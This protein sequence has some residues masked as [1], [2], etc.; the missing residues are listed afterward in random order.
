MANLA[1]RHVDSELADATRS[2]YQQVG[3]FDYGI[4]KMTKVS[5]LFQARE[6]FKHAAD[7]VKRY[8]EVAQ[9]VSHSVLP[10]LQ[11]AVDEQ[12]L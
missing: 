8:A 1:V 11:L 7:V 12:A 2:A 9:Q 5:W 6:L 10:D 3:L 4:L